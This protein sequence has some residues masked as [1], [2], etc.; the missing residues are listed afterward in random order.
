[1]STRDKAAVPVRLRVHG[2]DDSEIYVL[3]ADLRKRAYGVGD[4]T[5]ELPAGLYKVRAVRAGA[6]LE[7]LIDLQ[8]D[9]EVG[10]FTQPSS[11]I[12]PVGPVYGPRQPE[13]ESL[14]EAAIAS[15]ESRTDGLGR[16]RAVSTILLMAHRDVGS[17][18]DPL[19]EIKL[20]RWLDMR[21]QAAPPLARLERRI[22]DETWSAWAVEALPGCYQLE[23]GKG[24][25]RQ[26]VL[27]AQGYH[28]RVF[29]RRSSQDAVC[30]GQTPGG[31][32]TELSIQ[33]AR[34]NSD[35]FYW[36]HYETVEIARRAMETERPIIVG[37]RLV[38][39]LLHGKWDNPVMGVMGTHL[40]LA[41]LERD[42]EARSGRRQRAVAL[43]DDVRSE[44]A[45]T[46]R[47][48]LRNL[49]R[50]LRTGRKACPSDLIALH[51]RAR[52]FTGEE[53][54]FGIVREPPMFWASWESLRAAS[55]AGGPVAISR[56]LW[57]R[58]ARAFPTGPYFGWRCGRR[59]SIDSQVAEVMRANAGPT[60]MG[61]NPMDTLFSPLAGAALV[62]LRRTWR[63]RDVDGPAAKE[64]ATAL[65]AP[66]SLVE[67]GRAKRGR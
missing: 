42:G 54:S 24:A 27:V 39:Q 26:V 8:G 18:A 61:F 36:D 53:R 49:R 7:R 15:A 21:R 45:Q 47:V 51:L 10:L 56:Q 46:L 55:V 1:M 23:F 50:V 58:V 37:D 34:P 6:T 66:L 30:E 2:R 59:V 64:V 13:I 57:S 31:G 20:Y 29:I 22:G 62:G 16:G 11:A 14:A 35:V 65:G 63:D 33:M 9:L 28:T 4:V 67:G 12:A 43:T 3:D 48:V 60:I 32:K 44:A 19:G 38:N 17:A 5:A 40:F 25:L 41:A 52:P